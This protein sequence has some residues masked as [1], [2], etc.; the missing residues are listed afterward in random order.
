MAARIKAL[1][2][3]GPVARRSLLALLAGGAVSALLPRLAFGQT[4][5]TAMTAH[6]FSFTA[7][8]G[9]PLPMSQFKGKAVL[10]VNTASQCGYTPQYADLQ[11]LW[12]GYRERGLVVLGVPSNDFNQ[13]RGSAKEIKE[14]CEVNFEVDFPLA[15]KAKVTGAD[16]HPLYRWIAAQKGEDALPQWNFHKVLI[17]PDGRIVAIFP[18]RVRPT[19]PEVVTAIETALKAPR[20]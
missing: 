15:D 3:Q 14:F 17:G 5:K 11:K 19:A 13:E 1:P 18:T 9:Q 10:V 20:A 7:I 6:D 16:A 8:D 12:A 4:G 2:D